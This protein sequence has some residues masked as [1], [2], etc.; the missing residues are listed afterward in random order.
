[1]IKL[2]KKHKNPSPELYK[3]LSSLIGQT[4]LV[5]FK[6]ECSFVQV[7]G[8]LEKQ[9]H[10]IYEVYD[11]NDKNYLNI[12]AFNQMDVIKIHNN[13][14]II[15]PSSNVEKYTI[16]NRSLNE[17]RDGIN[18]FVNEKKN[19]MVIFPFP[20]SNSSENSRIRGILK[21]NKSDDIY[22]IKN[23]DFKSLVNFGI[24][25]V[26]DYSYASR[27]IYIEI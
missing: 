15:S 22:Y 26:E 25:C 19:V 4:V 18:E 14:I 20:F 8:K 2:K 7:E 27:S 16:F 24:E 23:K 13:T 12:I 6:T 9:Y 3:K 1:M 11:P 21:Y 10:N 17:I 5:T